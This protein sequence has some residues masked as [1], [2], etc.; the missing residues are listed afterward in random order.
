PAIDAL[1]RSA[2]FAHGPRVVGVL[3]SGLLNDGSAGLA[4]IKRCGGLALVQDPA[5]AIADEMPR[6]AMRATAVDAAV[7][8]AELGDLLSTMASR[9]A[10]VGLP[11]PPDLQLE[12]EIA[13]GERLDTPTLLRIAQ[14]SALTCP[15]CGG[16]MS[17]MHE[18]PPLRFRCQVGHAMTAEVLAR[19]QEDAVDEA[20]RVALRV[21]EERATLVERMA[22]EAASSGRP[23]IAETYEDRS[24]EYRHFADVLRTAVMATLAV[25]TCPLPPADTDA[26]AKK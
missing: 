17:V 25:D 23:H 24:R 6:S 11:A 19:E 13:A 18:A 16:V 12:V 20:M 26:P 22:R 2:A 10:G 7:P 5:D 1:F 15:S 8:A 4:A 3:L 14:P 9:P 21:I